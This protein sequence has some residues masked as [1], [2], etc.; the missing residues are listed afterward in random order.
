MTKM[1]K[2]PWLRNRFLQYFVIKL[3]IFQCNYLFF[4]RKQLNINIQ[5]L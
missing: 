2:K 5:N 4:L 3:T 1:D